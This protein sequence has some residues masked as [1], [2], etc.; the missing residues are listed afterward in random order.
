MKINKK[1]DLDELGRRIQAAKAEVTDE[2][3]AFHAFAIGNVQSVLETCIDFPEIIPEVDRATIIWRGIMRAAETA[4]FDGTTL[5]KCLRSAETDYLRQPL[6]DYILASSMTFEYFSE[7]RRTTIDD[8]TIT[9]SPA[10]PDRFS[11]ENLHRAIERATAIQRADRLAVVRTRVRARTEAAAVDRALE[12]ADF[13]RGIWNFWINYHMTMSYGVPL[14]PINNLTWGPVHTLHNVHG[15][16]VSQTVWSEP[17]H[18]QSDRLYKLKLSAA[19]VRDTERRVRQRLTRLQYGNELRALF[20][21][22]CRALDLV[23]HETAFNKLWSVF[24]HLAGAIGEYDKLIRRTI[25]LYNGEE[26]DLVRLILE[27]LRDVRNGL[28]HS[29][30]RPHSLYTY[31]YQLKWFVETLFFFHLDEGHKF[32]SLSAAGE[33]LSLSPDERFLRKRIAELQKAVRLQTR[34]LH[35]LGNI[36]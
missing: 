25:F 16:L 10:L 3:I 13:L 31:L 19:A 1:Y 14:G 20:V 34:P 23:D 4:P 32:S 35:E 33:F 29:D 2:R 7:L 6:Q 36:G 11:R 5:E 21:R 12:C 9:F 26:R 17:K 30:R 24:E 28:V 27:H 8:I 18:Q 22:Y 15:A